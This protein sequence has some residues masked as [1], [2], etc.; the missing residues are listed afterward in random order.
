[1]NVA[2]TIYGGL[3]AG[4]YNDV[5]KETSVAHIDIPDVDVIVTIPTYE[6]KTEASRR[7]LPQKLTHSEAVKSSAI[8]NTMICALAQ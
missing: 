2:P 5:S 7:A 6:L 8:S 4:F 3:I 1:D